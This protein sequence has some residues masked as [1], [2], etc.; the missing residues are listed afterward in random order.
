MSGLVAGMCGAR[1]SD[2]PPPV[3]PTRS[4]PPGRGGPVGA[5]AA[6][7]LPHAESRG[8]APSRAAPPSA[9]DRNRLR[10]RE[11]G[12]RGFGLHRLLMVATSGGERVRELHQAMAR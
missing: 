12:E 2:A 3:T 1:V 7:L 8:G 5:A 6:K 11:L 4:V 9:A 10:D